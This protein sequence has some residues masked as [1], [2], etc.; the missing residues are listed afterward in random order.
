MGFIKYIII[1]FQNFN[2]IYM[3]KNDN[4]FLTLTYELNITQPTLNKLTFLVI[5]DPI[6]YY[7]YQ[8]N[9]YDYF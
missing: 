6:I 8:F 4:N 2:D 7:F 1:V 5:R 3:F 9:K